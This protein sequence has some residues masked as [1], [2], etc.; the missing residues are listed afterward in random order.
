[1]QKKY[2]FKIVTIIPLLSGILEI[3][4]P[5]PFRIGL[6]TDM[7]LNPPNT[8]SPYTWDCEIHWPPTYYRTGSYA[9]LGREG[10]MCPFI[11]FQSAIAKIN[12]IFTLQY[13]QK[14]DLIVY[15]GDFVTWAD[16]L[17]YWYQYP[18]F[19]NQY[20][21]IIDTITKVV[22]LT[23]IQFPDVPIA[24]VIGNHDKLLQP[25]VPNPRLPFKD[26]EYDILYDLWFKNS[27]N[28][29]LWVYIYIYIL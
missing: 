3:T 27:P 13:N 19:L 4:T 16:N 20:K 18:D 15:T 10:C 5:S 9:P 24:Y 17:Y 1:M 11:L 7:H 26:N 2:L 22:Q 21:M 12:H 8:F 23:Q 25:Y 29:K 28:N 6:V 14:P